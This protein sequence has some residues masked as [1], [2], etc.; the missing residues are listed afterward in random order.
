MLKRI[1]HIKNVGSFHDCQARP[2]GCDKITL[3][4]GRNTYGKSTLG[5][6]FSSLQ[7]NDP[8]LILSRSSIPGDGSGQKVDLA[9][10]LDNESERDGQALFRQGIWEHPLRES[11]NLRVYDDA[12]FHEHVFAA[13]KFT[14]DTK[15]KFSDFILGEQGVQ[16][17]KDI[18]QKKSEKRQ[19]TTR[20]SVLIRDAFNNID[21]VDG[22]VATDLPDN[23]E[24]LNSTRDSLREEYSVLSGQKKEAAKISDRSELSKVGFDSTIVDDMEAINDIFQ[25]S[26]DTHHDKAKAKLDE[27]IRQNFNGD[28]GVERWLQQGSTINPEQSCGFCGQ[29]L[30]AEASD[31]IQAYRDYFNDEFKTHESNVKSNLIQLQ[32]KVDI[33]SRSNVKAALSQNEV[34]LQVYPDIK[35]NEIYI[36]SLSIYQK[37]SSET[38]QLLDEIEKLIELYIKEYQ[39]KSEK[40]SNQPHNSIDEIDLTELMELVPKLGELIDAYNTACENINSVISEFKKSINDE[41]INKRLDEINEAGKSISQSILRHEKNESC[42]EYK[43]ISQQLAALEEDIPKLETSLRDEQSAYLDSYFSEINRYFSSL[44]SHD[45]SLECGYDRSGHTPVYYLKVKFRGQDVSESD[46]DKV[47]SE[48]DRRALG[49]A[50]FMA[51]LEAINA[52]ELARTVV[53]FDDPVTSFDEHRVGQTHMKLMELSG[54]CEQIILLSHY[55]EGI[56][57]FIRT[58][59]FS[60]RNRIKL[61]II[62]KDHLTSKLEVGDNDVFIRTVHEEARENIIDFIERKASHLTCSPRVFLEAEISY[63]FGQQIRANNITNNSLCERI[64][65]LLAENIITARTATGL[66]RWRESLNPEH[67]VMPGNDIEDQRTTAREF[68]DF[69]YNDLV[70]TNK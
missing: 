10:A 20:K 49:L 67:H 42:V 51:S 7:R 70:P 2:V 33:K 65:A 50:V 48:S 62:T 12:F 14:R 60:N 46:L 44:G 30:D 37:S 57:H 9:F 28:R 32:T 43:R 56:A 66:H 23:I 27:H 8:N 25:S 4:F 35:D 22:F 1:S 36:S 39:H 13:R 55:K 24:E 16:T 58:Y 41:N 47:F 54:R 53:V 15:V 17:A 59:G 18:A 64:D 19:L 40:K 52:E 45:F 5:D 21:D 69:I 6:I 63:R 68:I 26:I 34:V 3:L 31:L 61:I 38:V 29:K 11:H